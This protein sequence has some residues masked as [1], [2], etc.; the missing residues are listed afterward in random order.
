MFVSHDTG[1]IYMARE[2]EVYELNF[3]GSGV[4]VLYTGS[5]GSNGFQ[6]LAVAYGRTIDNVDGGGDGGGGDGGDGDGG[7]QTPDN[8]AFTGFDPLLPAGVA[9]LFVLTGLVIVVRRATS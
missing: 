7:G 9:V 8:L 2:N 6:N 3:D 5:H 4:R 1:K